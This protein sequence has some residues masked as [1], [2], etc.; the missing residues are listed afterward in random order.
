MSR[1]TGPKCKKCRQLGFSVC[2]SLNCALSRRQTRPGMHAL[3]PQSVSPYKQRLTEKQK[4][5]FS[6][7]VS[8]RQLIRYV[9]KARSM[10]GLPGENLLK[11]LECRLDN[12]VYRLG[13]APTLHG[14]RQL[15]NHGHILVNGRKVDIP[16]YI[17]KPGDL[18]TLKEKS[19]TI[20]PVQQGFERRLSRPPFPYIE[21]D[22]NN[23]MGKLLHQPSREEIPL[24]INEN[25]IIEYY[26]PRL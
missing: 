15:V 21:L 25:L 9:R 1:Y 11:I 23:L 13:F 17:I 2:G 3:S 4:L 7:W 19:K 16:S 10:A 6:Y 5:R 12:I 24:K 20:L 14:A 22:E 18:I 26:A 8:E